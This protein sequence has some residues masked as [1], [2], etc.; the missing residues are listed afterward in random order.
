MKTVK[1]KGM[2]CQHCV[3]SVKNGLEQL[4]GIEDVLVN[5][6]Q[7]EVQFQGD[8]DIQQVVDTINKLGFEASVA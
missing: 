3:S 4:S 2:S 7:G 6:E 5:L 1:I 8:V